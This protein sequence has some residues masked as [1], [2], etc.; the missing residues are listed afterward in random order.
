MAKNKP[1]ASK[2]RMRRGSLIAI[3]IIVFFLVTFISCSV[4]LLNSSSESDYS[5]GVGNVALIDIKGVLRTGSSSD[6][7]APEYA[8]S[9]KI[10]KKIRD[11]EED[12]DIQAIVLEINSPGG[13]AVA[14]YEIAN[15]IK[16]SKKPTVAWIRE[17]GASGG[18]WIASSTDHIIT[19]PMSVTGSIGVIGSYLEFEGLLDDYNVTY[20]R[21]VAGK[22][23]DLGSPFKEML[24]EEEVLYQKKLDLI[25]DYFVKDVAKNRNLS[26]NKTIELATGIFYLGVEAK[27]LGLVDEL[28]GE[29]EVKDYLEQKIGLSN[30]KFK[31]YYDKRSIWDAFGSVIQD[32]S[33]NI[34]R[35]M[36][37]Y[38]SQD[39]FSIRT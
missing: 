20:R 14:S 35:G 31:K 10:I 39:R 19:N 3:I 29:N 15:E 4:M 13:G 28:G 32:A 23:K 26:E 2:K 38:F 9:T 34:G 22:Y 6:I 25:Y 11:A 16:Q 30:V 8:S 24:P 17:V 1:K 33:F 18:Y 21:L 5:S 12:S 37:S 7:F 27:E 36:A